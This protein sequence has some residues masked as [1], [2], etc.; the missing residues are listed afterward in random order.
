MYAKRHNWRPIIILAAAVGLLIGAAALARA[1]TG[2]PPHAAQ[3]PIGIDWA[4]AL[5]LLGAALGGLSVFLHWLA[6]R[7]KSTL[8]DRMVAELDIMLDWWKDAHGPAA[9]PPPLA[10]MR[11]P[12]AGHASS[13]VLH[14]IVVVGLC[15][16]AGVGVG[17]ALLGAP[18]CG[19]SPS[20]RAATIGSIDSAIRTAE[21]A[22]RTYEHERALAIIATATAAPPGQAPTADQL[23]AG[24]V[25]LSALRSKVDHVQLA[26][27]AARVADD[28]ARTINDDPSVASARTALADAITELT[29]LT[30]GKTP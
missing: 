19:G 25:A 29:T 17:V 9:A 27:D 26:L 5:G 22:L 18:G 13:G 4:F 16:A 30:G 1:A 8:D 21:G 2:D 15:G 20:S 7:T 24:R 28:A 10:A 6:P 12:Q 23:T 14:A 3:P 11:N